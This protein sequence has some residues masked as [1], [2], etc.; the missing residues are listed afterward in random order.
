M[1]RF[2]RAF[3]RGRTPA[4]QVETHRRFEPKP[5]HVGPKEGRRPLIASFAFGSQPQRRPALYTQLAAARQGRDAIL[6]EM[7]RDELT[8]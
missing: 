5:V 6:L 4:R 8:G 1:G 3:L 7:V 2:G